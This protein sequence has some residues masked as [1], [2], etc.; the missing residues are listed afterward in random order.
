MQ[1]DLIQEIKK[2]YTDDYV[3][4]AKTQCDYQIAIPLEILQSLQT[5]SKDDSSSQILIYLNAALSINKELYPDDFKIFTLVY[6]RK[7]SIIYYKSLGDDW[8]GVKMAADVFKVSTKSIY[9]RAHHFA[10]NCYKK[11]TNALSMKNRLDLIK[12]DAVLLG[13]EYQALPSMD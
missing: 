3:Y 5:E 1:N 4:W 2:I 13:G 9:S 11:A 7:P 6:Y 8:Y 12:Q 10:F